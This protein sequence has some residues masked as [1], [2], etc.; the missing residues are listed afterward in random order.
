MT[1]VEIH[2]GQR[3][4]R[5]T[6]ERPAASPGAWQCRC[7][8]G[9]TDA[10]P[11]RRLL[12]GLTSCGCS[13]I[14]GLDAAT[15]TGFAF[16]HDNRHVTSIEAGTIR[17][18][19]DGF[20]DKSSYLGRE[21]AHMC[22]KLRPDF[23][24]IEQPLRMLPG[25]KRTVKFMGEEEEVS[26]AGGGTNALILSNQIVSAYCTAARIKD[27]PFILIASATWRRQFLGFGRKPGWVRKDWKKAAR[28][29]CAD[30]KITVT[31]DDQADAVGVAFA[32][33]AAP[34]L[35]M[36]KHKIGAAA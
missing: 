11:E 7:S 17:A 3:F 31:N 6:I 21:L 16:Y 14:L 13:L 26:G 4:G 36:M 8:C 32:A 33:A 10:Y 5:L 9:G 1:Q 30:L 12:V 34:E 20:E 18:K 35:K 19:G 27:I 22:R 24:A 23:I 2:I 28:D 25:G 15:T 29:R